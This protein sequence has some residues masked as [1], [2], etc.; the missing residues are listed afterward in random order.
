MKIFERILRDKLVNYFE[1]N[2][3]INP[4]QHGFRRNHSCVTQLLTHTNFILSNLVE[5]DEVDCIYIDF[6]KAFDK[7]DHSILVDKLKCYG[8]TTKYLNWISDFLN[9]RF[10]TVFINGVCSY[11]A[12]VQ[13]GVPQGSVLGPLLFI[14]YINDLQDVI[15]NSN[16]YTFADDTKIVTK[17]STA[18]DTQIMQNNLNSIILWTEKNNMKLN[19]NKFEYINHKPIASNKNSNLLENLPFFNLN[20][21]YYASSLE[22]DQ[23]THVKD[24]GITVDENLNFKLHIDRLAKQCKQ[25][26]SWIFSVFDTR[27]KVPMLILFNSLVRSKIEYCSQIYNPYQIQDINKIEQIQRAFTYRITGMANFNYWERLRILGIMSLQRRRER[28]IIIHLWKILNN[29][30]PN[31]IDIEFK[32]HNRSTAIKAVVKPLPKLRGH[33]LTIFDESFA[34]KSAKLWN[35]L[36]SELTKIT[37]LESFKVH[38]ENFLSLLPDEPPLQGY[39][40][41]SNNSLTNIYSVPQF[42]F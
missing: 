6:A 29:I 30:S 34:V 9:N 21:V 22:I 16:M 19:N 7:V 11:S 26:S 35:I 27:D 41:K 37:C 17:I 4:N 14:V 18:N 15:E 12:P 20:K 8:I 10:Q 13:S 24:L 38:L 23:S 32:H 33:I 31:G 40:H 36:P 3:L 1:S 39:S 5:G 42:K 25:L 28:S 2:S